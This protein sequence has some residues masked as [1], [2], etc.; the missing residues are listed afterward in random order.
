MSDFERDR[1]EILESAEKVLNKA[2]AIDCSLAVNY[3]PEKNRMCEN[4]KWCDGCPIQS[5]RR[6]SNSGTTCPDWRLWNLQKSVEIVQAWSDEHP[7]EK[8]VTRQDKFI[9]MFA[10]INVEFDESFVPSICPRNMGFKKVAC[11][12]P[13]ADCREEFWDE[14]YKE[15]TN[16]Q[17]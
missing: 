9:E 4:Y 5:A 13:C 10:N 3:E 1:K 17:D 8:V 12:K 15:N 14:P 6:E 7:R 2:H 11:D 16:G